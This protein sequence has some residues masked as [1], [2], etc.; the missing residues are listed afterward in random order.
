M[1]EMEIIEKALDDETFCDLANTYIRVKCQAEAAY[2]EYQAKDKLT[3]AFKGYILE[4]WGIL[5]GEKP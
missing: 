5:Q 1:T 3:R 4:R 2:A